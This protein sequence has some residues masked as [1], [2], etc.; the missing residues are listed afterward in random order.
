MSFSFQYIDLKHKKFNPDLAQQ[1][2]LNKLAERLRDLCCNSALDLQVCRSESLRAHPVDWKDTT[3]PKGFAHLNPQLRDLPPY[4][5]SISR[6]KHGRVCGF[7]VDDIFFIVW[8]D[9]NH[10][11]YR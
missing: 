8:L 6:D 4:Q 2:Y 5:F 10:N 7:I 1:N 9:P 11:L 3:E